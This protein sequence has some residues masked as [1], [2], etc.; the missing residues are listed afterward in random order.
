MMMSRSSRWKCGR[1]AKTWEAGDPT[2]CPYCGA[3]EGFQPLLDGIPGPEEKALGRAIGDQ[4]AQ[5]KIEQVEENAHEHWKVVAA[6]AIEDLARA[7]RPF[8]GDDVWSRIAQLDPEATTHESR[9]MGPMI[10]K[11]SRAGLIRFTGDFAKAYRPSRNGG[12]ERL[13]IG[14]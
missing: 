1:C 4:R 7:G 9:A 2:G 11:A 13:W 10:Q 14:T 5:A 3:R 12:P 6:E 8:Q